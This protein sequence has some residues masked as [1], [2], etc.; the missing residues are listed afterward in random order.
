MVG[1]CITGNCD[2]RNRKDALI[3]DRGSA[4]TARS[5]KE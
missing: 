1:I 5:S 2:E 4:Q 3:A